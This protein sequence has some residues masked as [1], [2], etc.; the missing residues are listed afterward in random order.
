MT[1]SL[2]ILITSITFFIAG[3]IKGVVGLGLPTISLALLAMMFDLPTAI[4]LTLFP[5]LVTNIWQ[6]SSG[7]HA[8][9]ILNQIYPFLMMALI[10]IW[11][12]AYI[13]SAMDITLLTLLMGCLLSIYAILSL[14]G[15]HFKI[16]TRHKKWTGL[17]L[18]SLNGALT[19]MSGIYILPSVM[20][21]QAIGLRREEMMQAMGILFS[22]S[23]I[24]MLLA[25]RYQN[26]L[27]LQQT[28]L[29]LF[30][31]LP[32]V[33]GMHVGNKIRQRVPETT[34]KKILFIA[35]LLL[36]SIIISKNL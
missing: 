10:T 36:G 14:L 29:S 9:I 23:S 19:G 21:F 34:F 27:T 5:S 32:A 3:G 1:L 24:S 11:F 7:R 28:M 26:I 31:V 15:I 6:A 18:G 4:I 13:L 35:L 22:L 25:F 33:L 30:A 16:S 8:K 12:G 20:Y 2:M 17:C